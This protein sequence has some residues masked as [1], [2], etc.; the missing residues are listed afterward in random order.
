MRK[1]T[2]W[3]LIAGFTFSEMQRLT[4]GFV[5]DCYI[6]RMN[7]DDSQHGIQRGE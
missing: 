5:L 1:V 2:A 7:Y 3:G 6:Y 4:P